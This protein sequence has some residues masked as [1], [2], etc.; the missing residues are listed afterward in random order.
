MKIQNQVRLDW[1]FDLN[2]VE[3]YEIEKRVED[4]A[5]VKI[6]ELPHT[7]FS[8]GFTFF[9]NQ[10]G[11]GKITYRI[12]Y[13]YNNGNAGLSLERYLVI[14]KAA[15]EVQVFP[16]PLVRGETLTILNKNGGKYRLEIIG[17][18]GKLLER[19]ELNGH[20]QAVKLDL[21]VG[22]YFYRIVTESKMINGSLII[23]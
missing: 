3:K 4:N 9:D 12:K 7:A 14:K 6:G 8:T 20:R 11:E 2:E 5:F 10:P 1:Y 15:Y 23:Q 16:N 13:F 19:F 21:A 22:T 17:N 18:E